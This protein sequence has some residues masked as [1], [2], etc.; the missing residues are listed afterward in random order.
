M[1]E[2]GTKKV[3]FS[4][5]WYEARVHLGVMRFACENSWILQGESH[6]MP[7]YPDFS[8]DG[9]IISIGESKE[10]LEFVKKLN[11]PL[12]LIL[13]DN[14]EL[15]SPAILPDYFRIG[16]MAADFF[17]N[18]QYKNFAC[19]Y[20]NHFPLSQWH[21]ERLNGYIQRVERHGGNLFVRIW[22]PSEFEL[23][24]ENQNEVRYNWFKNE[25]AKLPLP[26]SIFLLEDSYATLVKQACSDL[27]LSVPED[28]AVISV[29]NDPF[30]C[31]YSNFPLTS[32]DPGWEN[33]GYLA[34]SELNKLMHGEKIPNKQRL[35]P[36]LG[37]IERQS[38]STI[39]V[40]DSRVSNAVSYIWNNFL[41][42]PSVN[43]VCEAINVSRRSLEIAFKKHLK[44]GIKQEIQRVRVR[45]IKKQLLDTNL[46]AVEISKRMKF[47]SEFYML[48]FFKKQTGMTTTEFRSQIH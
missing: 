48:N 26:L 40:D 17:I 24:Q 33:I 10:R 47:S 34:A 38:S 4:M 32:I 29:N 37:V 1:K 15:D 11:K 25:L 19:L 46:S 31:Q 41:D 7:F 39:A 27:N 5:E 44:H 3:F 20:P 30:I 9:Y 45:E 35:I 43:E 42:N 8:A 36:P 2:Q 16:E 28:V 21:E 12:L 22:S 23:S 6:H 14:D 18:R 13:T